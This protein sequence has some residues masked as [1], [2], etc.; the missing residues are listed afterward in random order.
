MNAFKVS[1]LANGA[2]LI[3]ILFIVAFKVIDHSV[4]IEV[5]EQSTHTHAPLAD[6]D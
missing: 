2:L 5:L 1:V 4:R 6:I 3:I